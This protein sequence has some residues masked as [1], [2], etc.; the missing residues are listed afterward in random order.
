MTIERSHHTID[1]AGMPLGRAASAIATILMGKHKPT[2]EPHIDGG[3][4]VRAVH[5]SG[6]VMTGKKMTDKLYYRPTRRI[7]ALSSEPLWRLWERRPEEVLRHAVMGML[8]KNSL[9]SSMIKR[10]EIVK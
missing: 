8:P 1:L 2:Y 10:L 3:D 5:L 4:F 6:V 9:R 7:G